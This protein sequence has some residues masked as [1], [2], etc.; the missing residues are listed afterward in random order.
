ML[1]NEEE[2]SRVGGNVCSEPEDRLFRMD[3]VFGKWHI[4]NLQGGL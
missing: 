3:A 4:H 2:I 1:E